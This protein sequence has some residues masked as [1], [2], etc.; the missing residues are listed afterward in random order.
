M[1]KLGLAVIFVCVVAA[2]CGSSGGGGSYGG[3]GSGS[4]TTASGGSA[5]V[6]SNLSGPTNAHGTGKVTG[7]KVTIELDD[8]Y[9]GPTVITAKAGEKVA[10]LLKNEGKKE[11]NFTLT[12]AKVNED[13]PAGGT[14]TVTVTVPAQADAGWYCEYHQKS[15]MQGSFKV[16]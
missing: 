7:G 9:F 4:A 8:D 10:I 2:G 16:T 11:H 13:I 15:G 3:G 14:K 6:P 5:A 12:A 1:R